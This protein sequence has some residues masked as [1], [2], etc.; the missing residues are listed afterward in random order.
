MPEAE[1]S[2]LERG[3]RAVAPRLVYRAA[4]HAGGVAD[5]VD[6]LVE[7][8]ASLRLEPGR[9]PA[10]GRERGRAEAPLEWD[11]RHDPSRRRDGGGAAPGAESAAKRRLLRA[12]ELG[13]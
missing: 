4:E 9:A 1:Y 7:Q 6:V 12:F 10:V 11:L 2:A 13:A 3:V 8:I 5:A